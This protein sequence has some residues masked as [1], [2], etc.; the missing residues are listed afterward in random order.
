L[1]ATA[2]LTSRLNST[3]AAEG[4][5]RIRIYVKGCYKDMERLNPALPL[6]PSA[7]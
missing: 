4:T 3:N 7:G 1:E 5:D 2:A 6:P